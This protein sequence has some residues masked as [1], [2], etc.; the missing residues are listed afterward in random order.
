MEPD[1]GR[2]PEGMTDTCAS[3]S[4]PGTFADRENATEVVL[5]CR[6]Q[7]WWDQVRVARDANRRLALIHSPKMSLPF[8]FRGRKPL[9]IHG[10]GQFAFAREFGIADRRYVPTFRPTVS[11]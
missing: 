1:Q 9:S 5:P 4:W 3:A 7:L 10:G 6:N 8:F 11:R 2:L